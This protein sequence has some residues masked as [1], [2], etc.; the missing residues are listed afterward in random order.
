MAVA[1]QAARPEQ[2]QHLSFV[3][4][5]NAQRAILFLSSKSAKCMLL[6]VFFIGFFHVLSTIFSSSSKLALALQIHLRNPMKLHDFFY[7]LF[8]WP[9]SQRPRPPSHSFQLRFRPRW[10]LG[11]QLLKPQIAGTSWNATLILHWIV[12]SPFYCPNV[13]EPYPNAF[14]FI[15]FQDSKVMPSLP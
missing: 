4:D 13:L 3:S 11:A 5:K 9:D 2:F 10:D 15:Q 6:V 14:N 7:H 8:H 1:I 12:G